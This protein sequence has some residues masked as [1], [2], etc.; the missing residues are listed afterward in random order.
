MLKKRWQ[1]AIC[2][3]FGRLWGSLA[4]AASKPVAVV[5]M[6]APRVRGNARSRDTTPTPI[7]GVMA[8]VKMELDC[9]SIVMPAPIKMAKYPVR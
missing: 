1:N 5:P 3:A 9:T 7:R 8:D 2:K 6:F 4:R